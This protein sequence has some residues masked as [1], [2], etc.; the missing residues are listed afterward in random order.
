MAAALA[1]WWLALIA[2][3]VTL[4]RQGRAIDTYQAIWGPDPKHPGNAVPPTGWGVRRLPPK[5][6][7]GHD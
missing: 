3:W 7:V 6:R 4:Q 5:S 1:L 2:L